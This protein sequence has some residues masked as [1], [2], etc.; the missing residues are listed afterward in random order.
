MDTREHTL[1]KG[2][3]FSPTDEELIT[4][5]LMRKILNRPQLSKAVKEVELDQHTPEDL[6]S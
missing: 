2:F 6:E 4:F 3:I 1:P 5:Y